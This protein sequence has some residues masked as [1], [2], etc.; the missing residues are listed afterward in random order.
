[1]ARANYFLIKKSFHASPEEVDLSALC[2]ET[3]SLRQQVMQLVQDVHSVS[4]Q[5]GVI[6][7]Q[8]LELTS[9][10]QALE[11]NVNQARYDLEHARINRDLTLEEMNSHH[12]CDTYH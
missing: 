9:R 1:M 3:E 5:V 10:R 11:R 12:V 2:S 7:F 6:S 8:Q 4:V